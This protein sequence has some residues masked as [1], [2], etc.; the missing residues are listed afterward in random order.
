MLIAWYLGP[1]NGLAAL[2]PAAAVAAPALA[3]AIAL[4]VAALTLAATA[5]RLARRQ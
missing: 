5:F 1:V 4:G 2:D 3:T